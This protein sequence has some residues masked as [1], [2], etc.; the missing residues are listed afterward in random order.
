MLPH[1]HYFHY[2]VFLQMENNWFCHTE[3]SEWF[4]NCSSKQEKME[5]IYYETKVTEVPSSEKN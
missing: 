2:P 1:Q 3:L 4:E 5:G